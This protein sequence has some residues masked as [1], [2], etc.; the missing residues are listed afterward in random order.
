MPFVHNFGHHDMGEDLLFR[1]RIALSARYE[2]NRGELRVALEDDF[3][4]FRLAIEHRDERISNIQGQSLR[5]PYSLCPAAAN[6]LCA[7]V[8]TPLSAASVMAGTDPHAQCT[9]LMDLAA[10]SAGA[11]ARRVDQRR[12]DVEIPSRVAGHTTARVSIDGTLTLSWK[13]QH[14]T[15][16]APE[17]FAQHGVGTGFAHWAL[18][19]LPDELA[20]AALV[21]RRCVIISLGRSRNLDAVAHARPTGHCYVQQRERAPTA[22][23]MIGST[24]DFSHAPERLCASDAS[25]LTFEDTHAEKFSTD[26]VRRD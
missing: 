22:Q 12:Y 24:L 18:A 3:H 15:I 13:I 2:R 1:R 8:H 4:H 10:L 9:H 11:A 26:Q 21:L 6:Q 5:I 17:P 7:L 20:T 19:S 16:L 25:W 14:L 23:R